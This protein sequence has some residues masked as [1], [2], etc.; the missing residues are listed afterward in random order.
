MAQTRDT[1][2]KLETTPERSRNMVKIK[3]RDTKPEILLRKAV[4]AAGLRGWCKNLKGI[5]GTPDIAFTKYKLAVFVD[6]DFW[7]GRDFEARK[8]RLATGNNGAY[9]VPKIEKNMERDARQM[10]ELERLGWTVLRFWSSD[11]MKDA[12]GCAVVV[13]KKLD[14]L[15]ME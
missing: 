14:E 13:V 10:A 8:F 6:G 11:V 12:V 3:S 9:W 5:P 7:H 15:K 4:W 1:A 2:M